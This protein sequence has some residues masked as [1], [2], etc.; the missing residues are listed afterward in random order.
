MT[1]TGKEE[2]NAIKIDYFKRDFNG[3]PWKAFFGLDLTFEAI[4]II[5]ISEFSLHPP[6]P[7][8]DGEVIV[9]TVGINRSR[10]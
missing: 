7:P 3:Y 8:R 4:L 2:R 6:P 5:M 10:Y 1:K 9:I